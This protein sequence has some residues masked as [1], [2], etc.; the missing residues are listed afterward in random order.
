MKKPLHLAIAIILMLPLTLPAQ[1]VNW[2]HN[3]GGVDNDGASRIVTDAAGNSYATGYFSGTATFGLITIT[4]HGGKDAF[5]VAYNPAGSEIWAIAIGGTGN[6]EGSAIC[7]DA[8]NDI[9]IAGFF[10]S[11][12]IATGAANLTNSGGDD[13]FFIKYNLSGTPL[14][15]TK[16]GGPGY[17]K[18]LSIATDAAGNLYTTGY[19]AGTQGCTF[20]LTTLTGTGVSSMFIAKYNSSLASQWAQKAGGLGATGNVRGTS[21]AIDFAGTPFIVGPF[22]SGADFVV[23]QFTAIGN[24]D[25]FLAKYNSTNGTLNSAYQFYGSSA[26]SRI[27]PTSLKMDPSGFCNIAGY[28]NINAVLGSTTLTSNG[29]DDIF[30]TRINAVG[31]P[32]WAYSAGGAGDDRATG[33]ALDASGNLFISGYLD[34]SFNFGSIPATGNSGSPDVFVAKYNGASSA[35]QWVSTGGTSSGY[36]YAYDIASASSN[37][38]IIAG[39]ADAA[40][41]LGPV[42]IANAGFSD[43]FI[44]NFSTLTGINNLDLENELVVYPNPSNGIIHIKQNAPISKIELVNVLGETIFIEDIESL[45]QNSFDLNFPAKGI[46]NGIYFL[47]IISG[48]NFVKQKLIIKC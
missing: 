20:G 23:Q 41:S 24:T 25:M 39:Q 2:A 35:W 48:R 45:Q 42:S 34:G 30:I 27:N 6:D 3:F 36:E 13:I 26:A 5:L 17:E 8:N 40:F 9:Y 38:V 29:A 7:V 10:A 46:E 47:R 37:N 21:L 32:Q 44:A 15:A 43:G 28:F 31:N 12:T 19:I 1:S 4:S 18:C 11:P 22:L 16:A 33:L 14:Y